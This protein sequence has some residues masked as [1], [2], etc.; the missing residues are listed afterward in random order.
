MDDNP[1][2]AFLLT[3]LSARAAE[4]SLPCSMDEAAQILQQRTLRVGHYAVL[5]SGLG[6]ELSQADVWVRAAEYHA[7]TAL[8]GL[9]DKHREDLHL[10]LVGPPGACENLRWIELASL[11]ERDERVCRKLVWLPPQSSMESSV[12][13]FLNRTF[14]ARPWRFL[15]G[16]HQP[17][18]DPVA[19]IVRM[20]S[21]RDELRD[22]PPSALRQWLDVLTQPGDSPDLVEPLVRALKESKQ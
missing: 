21:S 14:L 19:A 13:T 5:M 17:R 12:Q 10:F 15:E 20:L 6:N 7:A 4:L 3:H 22:T 2:I 18:L 11:I 9:P 1:A 16:L 8:S